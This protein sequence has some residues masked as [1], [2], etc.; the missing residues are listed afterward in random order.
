[1]F[2]LC[3]ILFSWLS[4]VWFL[5]LRWVVSLVISSDVFMLFLLCIDVGLM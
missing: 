5:V 4:R 1:M 2:V 3:V